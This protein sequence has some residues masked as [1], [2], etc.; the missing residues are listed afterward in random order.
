LR[1]KALFAVVIIVIVGIIALPAVKKALRKPEKKPDVGISVRTAWARM[2]SMSSVVEVSGDIKALKS[3][4]LSAKIPG[5]VVS[6]PYREGDSVRAGAVIVQQ[7][8]S[9]LSAQVRQAEAALLSAKARLSQASTSAGLSDTQTEAQIAQAKAGLEAAKANLTK[10]KKGARSQEVASAENAVASAKANFENARINLDRMRDL[11]S[12]GA[13]SKQQMDLVQMQYDVASAQYD[14]AKQQLS[15]V[16]AGAREEDI[17]AAQKQVEQAE[18]ALRIAKSNRAQKALRQED[19]KS[20]RAGVAQAEAALAY[21]R[22]QL[23]NAYIRT[24]IAGTVSKRLTEPGQMANPGSSLMEIVALDTVYFEALVSEIDVGRVRA[25][26]PVQVTIDAMP[27][28][29]FT[30]RVLKILPTA[31]PKSRQFTVRIQVL[32]QGGELRPGMFARGSIEVD[33]RPNTVI[34]PKDAVI[35]HGDGRAVYLVLGSRAKLQP[36][37]T[38]FETREEVEAL[39]GVSAGDELVVVGQEKL[40]DGVKV[41]VAD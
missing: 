19:I 40:S 28:R 33:R 12:Q 2:G 15:L 11:Y 41:H 29:K 24:P 17:E 39:S 26:Q 9:D 14:T 25:G 27:G 3:V 31:D 37:R 10:I 30:G 1:R 23:A 34:I 21:A 13:L 38:G 16:K 18:E 35:T 22:Q 32:N 36:I 7:D 8:T 6:V 5:S 20:A 4:T